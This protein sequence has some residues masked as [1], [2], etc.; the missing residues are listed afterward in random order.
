MTFTAETNENMATRKARLE[1]F[2]TD[3]APAPGQRVQVLAEDHVGTYILPF[4]CENADGAWR[5]GETGEAV[6]AHIQGW[7][8]LQPLRQKRK[9]PLTG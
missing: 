1:S 4:P 8:E 7:R 9:K 2:V 6:H 3:R 5:N